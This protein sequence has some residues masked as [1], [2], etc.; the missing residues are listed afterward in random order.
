MQAIVILAIL[1][2]LDSMYTALQQ[3]FPKLFEFCFTKDFKRVGCYEVLH[4]KYASIFYVPNSWL[5]IVS[6]TAIAIIYSSFPEYIGIGKA[7][8][9]L[10]LVFGWY[11]IYVQ[12]FVLKK[13]C[14][15]CLTS[16]T[17]LT[18]ITILAYI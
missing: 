9:S 2:A 18:I 13:F 17:L 12:A 7:I 8:I 1:G 10:G 16:T 5:G 6:Y 15:F 11:L 14:I 4:S 3:Q